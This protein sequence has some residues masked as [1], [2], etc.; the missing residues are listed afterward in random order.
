MNTNEKLDNI[1]QTLQTIDKDDD[2]SFMKLLD[3]LKINDILS[4]PSYIFNLSNLFLDR[5]D[6]PYV[7]KR[8]FEQV[9]LFYGLIQR[10]GKDSQIKWL[11]N[12]EHDQK[13][14]II[15]G[16]VPYHDIIGT[17]FVVKNV[18]LY[19]KDS[20][21]YVIDTK[22]D[23]DFRTDQQISVS[24]KINFCVIF[25]VM[26]QTDDISKTHIQ[27]F[28]VKIRDTK[29]NLLPGVVIDH[30]SN[31]SVLNRTQIIKFCGFKVKSKCIMNKKRVKS[32]NDVIDIFLI[33][34]LIVASKA[35]QTCR[36]TLDLIHQYISNDY[37]F[38]DTSSIRWIDFP[39]TKNI[40][41]RFEYNYTY[42][43]NLVKKTKMLLGEC[44]ISG[45]PPPI[46]LIEMINCAKIFCTE[47]ARNT[48]YE[49]QSNMGTICTH[50]DIIPKIDPLPYIRYIVQ[51][52]ES[53]ILRH[54]M[55]RHCL[56]YFVN[57]KIKFFMDLLCGYRSFT[58]LL[59]ILLLMFHIC[60]DTKIRRYSES[61]SWILNYENIMALSQARI[62]HILRS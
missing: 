35:I 13:N 37:M 20:D 11:K 3:V 4:N 49:I 34:K 23:S 26:K 40:F 6:L 10:F 57:H 24:C 54:C 51:E 31:G 19:D 9:N 17:D 29:G 47:M 50:I 18:A 25:A 27:P 41:D 53:G 62:M 45:S 22:I 39:H 32:S 15:I 12:I 33:L 52:G 14:S 8:L 56:K 55:A 59:L 36:K 44:L 21:Q 61:A 42:A 38:T 28:L 1:K 7:E 5:T 16:S 30:S 2:D 60:I 43:S 48:I 46:E 58:E